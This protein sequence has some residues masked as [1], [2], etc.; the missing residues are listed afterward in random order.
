M[1]KITYC[2]RNL[3]LGSKPVYKAMKSK[4]PELKHKKK[5]CLG[6]CKMC[7]REFFVQVGKSKVVCEPSAKKL[8]KRLRELIG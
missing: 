7:S 4:F 5:D 3:K 6:N 2:C 8:Y 1:K